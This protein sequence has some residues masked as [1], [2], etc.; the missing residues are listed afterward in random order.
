MTCVLKIEWLGGYEPLPSDLEGAYIKSFNP[1]G[2]DGRGDLSAT[3]DRDQAMRFPDHITALEYWRQQSKTHP[4]RPDG[5]PNRP[6]T[7]FSMSIET[8]A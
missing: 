4:L 6:L 8:V 7:A 1:D 5:K 3:R 2:H